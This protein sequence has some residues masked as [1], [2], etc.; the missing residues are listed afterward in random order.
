MELFQIDQKTCNKDGI[1]AAVCPS[2]IIGFQKGEYPR[3]VPG[4]QVACIQ[5]GHCVAVCPTGSLDHEAMTAAAC[6][7][8]QP[9]YS[10]SAEQTEHFLR[11]RRSIRAYKEKVVDKALIERLIHIARYAPSGRNTQGVQWLVLGQSD[12]IRRIAGSVANW[13]RWIIDNDP[14]TA[15]SMH[16]DKTLAHWEKGIDIIFRGAPVVIVAHAEEENPRAQTTCTIALTY[17]ELAA[18][19]LGLGC[20]WA[21]YFMKAAD[22]YPPLVQVLALPEGHRCYGA[23]MVGYPKYKYHR[24]PL[25]NEPTITWRIEL[26]VTSPDTAGHQ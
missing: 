19:G 3:L 23:M 12:E 8:V 11:N 24:L 14:E 13:M 25:R 21:G 18:T 7:Q 2:R 15:A 4:G 20:C 5:C 22:E 10:L 17:L 6:P 1:C 9:D 16:L 26:P